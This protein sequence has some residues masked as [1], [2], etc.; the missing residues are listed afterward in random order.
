MAIGE[1]LV[2][3]IGE[4]T[5]GGAGLGRREGRP[6][7]VDGT[8]PGDTA[9]ARITEE[10]RD[11]ARAD[12]VEIISPSPDRIKPACPLYGSCGGCSLQHITYEAQ[13]AAKAGILKDA[14][15]R[16]GG[17]TP[18]EPLVFPSAPWEYRNRMEFHRIPRPRENKG[19]L[20]PVGLKARKNT[21]IIPLS[22]CPVAD[23]EIRR[24]LKE[25]AVLPPPHKDRFT[26]Y[27]RQGLFLSEGGT[28]RGRVSILDREL[29]LD[30]GVFFQ[31]NGA[32]LEALGEDLRVIA[33]EADAGLPMADLYC[34]AGVFAALLGNNFPQVDLVEA[35]KT[36]LALAREN[37]R[38]QGREFFALRDD[39]WV[40]RKSHSRSKA[41]GF[42]I[43]DPPRQGLSP[44]LAR[45]IAAEGPP[46]FAYVSCDPATL[47]RDSRILRAGGYTLAALR[48]YDFYPQ[49]AHIESLAVFKN[50][51]K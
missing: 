43:A 20:A 25:K 45:W 21:E 14:F 5:T 39:E 44:G 30:A 49:T 26:V 32:M 28:S 41:Y 17:F 22:D 47:A 11:W 1:T 8:A 42:I 23:P 36:A 15:I 37:V 7:F 6:V 40:K 35:N 12:L 50:N 27:A 2:F 38:G 13:V 19:G 34:G 4:I 33:G 24:A 10:H 9:A 29:N 51:K 31:S 18:P 46:L 16:L 3:Q 48:F